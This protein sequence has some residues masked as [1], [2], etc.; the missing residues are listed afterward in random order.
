MNKKT[1]WLAALRYVVPV[2]FEEMMEQQA[3][4][5]WNVKKI[6]Q[7]SSIK[8]DFTKTEPKTY[9]YVYDVNFN[10]KR[11]Y[12]DTYAQFGWEFVG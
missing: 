4:A 12:M 3:K 1:M 7:W 6:G 11:D 2:D 8:L 10:P 5:G 9:R